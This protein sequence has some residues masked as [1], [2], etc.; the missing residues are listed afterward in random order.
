MLI[1]GIECIS[2]D[3]HRIHILF[4]ITNQQRNYPKINH[5]AFIFTTSSQ[6]AKV[7]NISTEKLY[8]IK[9]YVTMVEYKSNLASNFGGRHSSIKF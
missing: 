3:I 4:Q 2:F 7:I 5:F 6:S 1:I 8:L 9:S